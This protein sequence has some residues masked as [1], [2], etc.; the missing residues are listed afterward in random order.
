MQKFTLGTLLVLFCCFSCEREDRLLLGSWKASSVTEA[1]DSVRLDP[2]QINFDFTPDNRYTFQS[3]L[4][5]KEAGTWT[6]NQDVLT[7]NDTTRTNTPQRVV[8]V[9]KLTLDSLVLRMNGEAAE[10]TVVLLRK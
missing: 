2:A 6:F 1:G 3:T 5:Y 7:A 9:D 10:R 4:K 8:A